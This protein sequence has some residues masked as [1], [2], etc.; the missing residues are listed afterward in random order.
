MSKNK[1]NAK[2]FD[3]YVSR[4]NFIDLKC[5]WGIE[6]LIQTAAQLD[7]PLEETIP[8]RDELIKYYTKSNKKT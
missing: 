6:N 7:I 1:C 5:P 3:F 4:Y 2:L 8:T